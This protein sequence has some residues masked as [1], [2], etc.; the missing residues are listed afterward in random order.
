MATGNGSTTLRRYVV[1]LDKDAPF[2]RKGAW[3]ATIVI[4]DDGYFSTV[5]DYGNYAFYWSH[6]GASSASSSRG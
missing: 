4:G 3:L 5:S 6:A 1:R 2:M